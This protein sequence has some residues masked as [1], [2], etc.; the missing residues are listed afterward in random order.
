MTAPALPALVAARSAMHPNRPIGA[1]GD[2]PGSLLYR[3]VSATQAQDEDEDEPMP[4][5]GRRLPPEDVDT[6][7]AWILEGAPTVC[8]GAE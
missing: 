1:P 4:P 5:G 2:P 3:E 6:I 7:E 8:E